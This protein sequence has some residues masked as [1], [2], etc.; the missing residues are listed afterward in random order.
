VTIQRLV[1]LRV[2]LTDA[3]QLLEDPMS[4]SDHPRL[5]KALLEP[6]L[7]QELEALARRDDRPLAAEVRRA[8][9]AHVGRKGSRADLVTEITRDAIARVIAAREEL[10]IGEFGQ[11]S[12]ILAD[13]ES[14]LS[15][16]IRR[17]A[18]REA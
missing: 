3:G 2:G 13:L 14:D 7:A 1:L 11:A 18:D 16:A 6:E 15:T 12:S 4:D 5:V 8:I 10:E 17:G 9:R